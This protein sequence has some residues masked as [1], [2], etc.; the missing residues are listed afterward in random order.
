MYMQ[1]LRVTLVARAPFSI[2]TIAHRRSTS[3]TSHKQLGTR[4]VQSQN[5]V[6]APN[7]AAREGYSSYD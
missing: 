6:R 3:A 5:K 4:A 1:T 7:K 2:P